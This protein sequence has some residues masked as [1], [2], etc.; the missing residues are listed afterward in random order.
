MRRFAPTLCCVA[1]VVVAAFV[2]LP[3]RA[4]AQEAHAAAQETAQ[5][6]VD[7]ITPH[8]TDS[9]HLELPWFLPPFHKELE[10]P[11]FAPVHVGALTVDLSPTKH[12][13]FLL[14]AAGLCLWIVVG[15]ARAHA[16]QT[17]AQ[18]TPRGVAAAVEA[19]V[20]YLRSEIILPNVGPHGE[21]FVPFCLTLFFFILF[22]NLLGLLPWGSTATGNI[23]VTATL[24]IVSFFVIE[25]AGMRA[26]GWGYIKTIVYWPDDMPLLM[27][28]PMTFIMTP[29]EIIGKIVKPF[30]LMLRLFANMTAGHFVILALLG[31]VF[32]FGSWP[33]AAGSVVFVVFMMLLELLVAVL[34]AYIF[35]LLTSVFIGMMQ[36]AN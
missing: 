22:G 25:I 26:L 29:I 23:S 31:L 21:A 4:F 20:L 12:V 11:R 1:C 3:A 2:L 6:P 7:F 9:H 15:S 8:I 33:V 19:V 24:A 32:I 35:A 34:Q 10:L 17:A 36:H 5:A 13:I 28:A 16:R 14:F 27:K 30:A 18:G